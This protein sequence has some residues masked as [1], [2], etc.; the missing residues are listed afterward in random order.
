ML[1]SIY[2]M[3]FKLHKKTTHFLRANIE[4]CHLLLNVIMEVIT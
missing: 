3:T 4:I 1:D 2:H